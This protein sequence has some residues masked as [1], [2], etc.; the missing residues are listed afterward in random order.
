MFRG[1]EQLWHVSHVLDEGDLHLAVKGT[2]PRALSGL[3]AQ[4][5]RR[6]DEHGNDAVSSV[7]AAL[8]E[9]VSDFFVGSMRPRDP[10]RKPLGAVRP[11]EALS[12]FAG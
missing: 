11:K 2:P 7:P 12:R 3:V 5:P 9:L 8:A 6:F 1:A 10:F 4:A